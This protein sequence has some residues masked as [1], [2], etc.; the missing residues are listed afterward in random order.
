MEEWDGGKKGR[1]EAIYWF[2]RPSILH[3]DHL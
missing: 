1:M 3:R 2:E